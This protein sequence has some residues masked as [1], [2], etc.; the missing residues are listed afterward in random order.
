[1]KRGIH[2]PVTRSLLGS[3]L[4]ME[5][6]PDVRWRIRYLLVVRQLPPITSNV[7]SGIALDPVTCALC[8]R[9]ISVGHTVVEVR[10][11]SPILAHGACVELWR[12]ECDALSDEA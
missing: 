10:C 2:T 3:S 5:D 9:G 4:R 12:E 1:M 6:A 7:V 11:P 8:R